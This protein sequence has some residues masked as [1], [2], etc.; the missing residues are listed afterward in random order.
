MGNVLDF[1][2][3]M[4]ELCGAKNAERWADLIEYQYRKELAGESVF[5]RNAADRA[6]HDNRMETAFG[7]TAADEGAKEQCK[8]L[9]RIIML[10]HYLDEHGEKE[11]EPI[12]ESEYLAAKAAENSY[13][14]IASVM[15]ADVALTEYWAG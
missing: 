7:F 15:S 8:R 11:L 12:I 9:A 2:T 4:P 13:P 3:K 6:N 10:S 5:A 14:Q 1:F